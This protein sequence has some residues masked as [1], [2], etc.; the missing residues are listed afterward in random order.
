[1]ILHTLHTTLF[2]L[3]AQNQKSICRTILAIAMDTVWN[4]NFIHSFGRQIESCSIVVG[5]YETMPS[6]PPD[7]EWGMS[8]VP[9]SITIMEYLCYTLR[10]PLSCL[11][12]SGINHK[13]TG[14]SSR[15]SVNRRISTLL[16]SFICYTLFSSMAFYYIIIVILLYI[17]SLLQLYYY[18]NITYTTTKAFFLF[19]NDNN[20]KKCLCWFL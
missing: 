5:D 6:I 19:I 15:S 2:E 17:F 7:G 20:N 8:I 9:R 10:F 11:V 4:K 13:R 12:L 16:L 1:M 18:R 14:S 3:H